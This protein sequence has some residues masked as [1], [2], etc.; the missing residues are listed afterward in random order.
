VKVCDEISC[1]VKILEARLSNSR[2]DCG[3]IG[4]HPVR[5]GHRDKI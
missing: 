2:P 5:T 3:V 4:M 1:K